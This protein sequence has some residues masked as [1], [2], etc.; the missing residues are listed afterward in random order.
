MSKLILTSNKYQRR[1]PDR[2]TALAGVGV[3]ADLLE[4]LRLRQHHTM[5]YILCTMYYILYAICHVL[6]TIRYDTILY[7]TILTYNTVYHTI[8]S[9]QYNVLEEL[10]L[11]RLFKAEDIILY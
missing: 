3:E 4:E 7:Q 1:R 8:I 9:L 2:E 6:Y 5:Y 11:R 10:R